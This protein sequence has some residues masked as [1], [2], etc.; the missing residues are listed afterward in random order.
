[1]KQQLPTT[2]MSP[3]EHGGFGYGFLELQ[4]GHDLTVADR[5]PGRRFEMDSSPLQWG[6]DLTVADSAT[7]PAKYDTTICVLQTLSSS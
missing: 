7:S 6:R 5:W 1:M 2:R 4:W 3:I